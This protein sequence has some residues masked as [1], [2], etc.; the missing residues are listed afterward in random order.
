MAPV[1]LLVSSLTPSTGNT[2]STHRLAGHL[3]SAGYEVQLVDANATCAAEVD[4]LVAATRAVAVI[5]VH[6]YRSGRHLLHCAAPVVLLLSG[7]DVNE[8]ARSDACRRGPGGGGV[9]SPSAG[10]PDPADKAGVI[11]YMVRRAAA[12]V[13]FSEGMRAAYLAAAVA[14]G[15]TPPD[16]GGRSD[17][18]N[19]C[20][21]GGLGG[22]LGGVRDR[23]V[24]IPQSVSGLDE[25]ADGS[26]PAD[27]MRSHLGIAAGARVLLL[28]CGLRPVKAPTF[29]CPGFAAW[30]AARRA[31]QLA[32]GTS[33]VDVALIIVGPP[34]EEAT[35]ASVAAAT[36]C[37]AS[38]TSGDGPHSCGATAE[39]GPGASAGAPPS[40][41]ASHTTN[42]CA[43][44]CGGSRGLYY[45]P[46]VPRARLLAWMAQAD[47]VLNTSESEGMPNAVM[48]AQATGTPVVVRA[49]AGNLSVVRGGDTGLVFGT[50]EEAFAAIDALLSA[51][52]AA[53]GPAGGADGR[54]TES[55][56]PQASGGAGSTPPAPCAVHQS[57]ACTCLRCR[58]A[59][60]AKAH[61]QAAHSPEAE[62]AAWR[63][64]LAILLTLVM[65][66]HR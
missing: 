10:A 55:C 52:C 32:A 11:H 30:R 17:A 24:V 64:L 62:T 61:I 57:V 18:G 66:K 45:H 28:P 43:R 5:G 39:A 41:A 36:G 4:A 13:A 49:N 50:P 48:E 2:V 1:V 9:G 15:A 31:A 65:L 29:L 6:A 27:D 35:A 54:A 38:L 22:G 34:L 25:V 51:E 12:V 59:S 63:A 19:C 33:S 46:A 40:P 37:D 53:P 21:S 60:A 8:N 47:A 20:S 14:A 3:R 16:A 42:N 58:L 26:S 44:L 56:I 7:T 23:I